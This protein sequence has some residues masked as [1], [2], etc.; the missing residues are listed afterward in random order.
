[1]Y[2]KI[3]HYLKLHPSFITAFQ[4][5]KNPNTLNV[6]THYNKYLNISNINLYVLVLRISDI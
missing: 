2:V 4:E 5:N 6:D 3:C 1:M